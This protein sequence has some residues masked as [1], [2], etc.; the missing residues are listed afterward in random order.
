[1]PCAE[2]RPDTQGR[3]GSWL[4]FPT[5]VLRP[6]PMGL[7]ASSAAGCAAHS[8]LSG[9]RSL[10]GT[11]RQRGSPPLARGV[12]I[13]LLRV[14]GKDCHH[15]L[16]SLQ[17]LHAMD[18]M[19]QTVV[20]DSPASSL[21]KELQSILQVWHGQSLWFAGAVLHAGGQ[22]VA[23]L[24]RTVPPQCHAETTLQGGCQPPVG[25]PGAAHH[26]LWEP[27]VTW[28]QSKSLS[29]PQSPLVSRQS[30]A[31]GAAGT[32]LPPPRSPCTKAVGGI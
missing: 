29:P 25:E 10:P 31:R 19:L 6:L 13:R 7:A 27:G 2:R 12:Q 5:L 11:A 9:T 3:A 23:T 20:L 1:M 14:R 32:A 28:L 22:R 30:L 26:A 24:E 21:S 16:S 15:P 4:C 18:T 8:S 17:T